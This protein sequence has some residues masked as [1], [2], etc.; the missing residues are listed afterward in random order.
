MTE[1]DPT[2]GGQWT[3]YD[4]ARLDIHPMSP[5]GEVI[6]QVVAWLNAHHPKPGR[7]TLQTVAQ[8]GQWQRERDAAVARA[9]QMRDERDDALSAG[10]AALGDA[11]RDRDEWKARA[12]KAE[13]ANRVGDDMIRQA[14]TEMMRALGRADRAEA[15]VR[16]LEADDRPAVTPADIEKAIRGEDLFERQIDAV[17][18]L[19]SG[20]DPV[21]PDNPRSGLDM[22]L[23]ELIR[24][25]VGQGEETALARRARPRT[26]GPRWR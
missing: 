16:E 2:A 17:W 5:A 20:D 26:G 10:L 12:E 14:Q 21:V 13:K 25:A 19:L 9:E 18:A 24:E 3:R 8:A 4:F 1:F 15:R 22:T 7:V 11:E 23:R 6:D